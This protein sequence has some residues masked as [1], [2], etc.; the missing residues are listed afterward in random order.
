MPERV[1]TDDCLSESKMSVTQRHRSDAVSGCSAQARNAF[2][3]L[4]SSWTAEESAGGPRHAAER[5]RHWAVRLYLARGLLLPWRRSVLRR[6]ELTPR[7]VCARDAPAVR[8]RRGRIRPSGAPALRLSQ[9]QQP[10]GAG[11]CFVVGRACS[12]RR[13]RR[14]GGDLQQ[15]KARFEHIPKF[16]AAAHVACGRAGSGAV[17][18]AKRLR[19]GA[20][21]AGAAAAGGRARRRSA[22]DCVPAH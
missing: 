11:E 16:N 21:L 12:A 10:R 14:G 3:H 4:N 2:A 6:A 8:G 15:Q 5:A 13:G 18:A 17:A 7:R 1:R 9:V 22:C 19:A 20:A